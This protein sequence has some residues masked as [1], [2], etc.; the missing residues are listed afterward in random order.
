MTAMPPPDLPAAANAASQPALNDVTVELDRYRC[1]VDLMAATFRRNAA[2][3][4]GAGQPDTAADDR[5]AQARLSQPPAST[6]P[7]AIELAQ[8]LL[9]RFARMPEAQSDPVRSLI[10]RAICDLGRIGGGADD[11]S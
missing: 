5:V 6:L 11:D 7:G 9:A 8:F 2:C 10:R 3:R 4:T 1:A